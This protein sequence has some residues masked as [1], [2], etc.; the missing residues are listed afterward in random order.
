MESDAHEIAS[1]RVRN[2]IEF[3][4]TWGAIQSAQDTLDKKRGNAL[5]RVGRDSDGIRHFL[6]QPIDF[7]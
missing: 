7:K 3:T 1:S 6:T 2:S 4:P 5:E